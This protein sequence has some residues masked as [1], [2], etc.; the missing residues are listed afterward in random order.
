MAAII[1]IDLKNVTKEFS[2]TLALNHINLHFD[3][4]GVFTIIGPSG[5]G[6]TTLLKIL[7][8]LLKPTKGKIFVNNVNVDN[9][10]R[11]SL[12]RKFTMVFQNAL[13]F[14]SNVH[15]NISYGL[16]IRN[17]P[18]DEVEKRIRDVLK[19]FGLIELEK[20][21]MSELS[22]GQM[23]RVS[24]ARAF[25]LE[26]D[27]LFLDE[28]TANLDPENNSIM[29]K[30]ILSFSK[31][32]PVVMSTHNIMQIY[33]IADRVAFL[34]DGSLIDIGEKGIL[35]DPQDECIKRF[36]AGETGYLNNNC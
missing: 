25:V 4:K 6:K 9:N 23:Q 16:K 22:V 31:T 17:L 3:N 7:A 11:H 19:R 1:M 29:E 20:K 35:E 32:K 34:S 13:F 21:L 14:N 2:D 12:R 5:A 33:R 24:L 26:P 28:P 8:L 27:I 36:V 10:M 30:E 18:S 15:D